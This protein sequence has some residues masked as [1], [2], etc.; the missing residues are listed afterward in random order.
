MS[1]SRRASRV[2]PRHCGRLQPCE[3][4]EHHQPGRDYQR[5]EGPVALTECTTSCPGLCEIELVCPVRANWRKINDVVVRSL[6]NLT[7]ADMTTPLPKPSIEPARH[8][9]GQ[10][11]LVLMAKR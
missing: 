4:L 8:P 10:P 9:D 2:S 1:L 5:D 11:H 3:T 6:E 7:L